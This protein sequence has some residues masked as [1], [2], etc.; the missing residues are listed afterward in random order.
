M[1][2]TFLVYAHSYVIIYIT[3]NIEFWNIIVTF[4][5][6]KGFITSNSPL[7]LLILTTLIPN[8]A[9]SILDIPKQPLDIR[10]DFL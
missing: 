7:W 4:F 2:E 9:D 3:K 6:K 5:E 10:N 1:R 8:I